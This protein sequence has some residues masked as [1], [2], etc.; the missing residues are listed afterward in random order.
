MNESVFPDV[1]SALQYLLSEQQEFRWQAIS[2]VRSNPATSLFYLLYGNCN[3]E[4]RIEMLLGIAL[5]PLLLR[6]LLTVHFTFTEEEIN[7]VK[8][9]LKI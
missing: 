8:K 4:D 1:M 5:E 6:Y 3:E 7:L 2:K 9:R